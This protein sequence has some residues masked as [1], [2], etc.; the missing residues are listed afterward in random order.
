MTM[1]ITLWWCALDFGEVTRAPNAVICDQSDHWGQCC[2]S[3]GVM[4]WGAKELN[5]TCITEK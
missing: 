5:V 4:A 1:C 3:R 2:W